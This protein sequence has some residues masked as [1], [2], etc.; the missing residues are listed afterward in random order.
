MDFRALNAPCFGGGTIT[1]AICHLPISHSTFILGSS[2]Q[3]PHSHAYGATVFT[4]RP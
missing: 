2:N 3:V 4:L 1:H